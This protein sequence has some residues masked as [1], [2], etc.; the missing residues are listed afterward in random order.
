M[1]LTKKNFN[2]TTQAKN[3]LRKEFMKA[4]SEPKFAKLIEDLKIDTEF[5][6]KYTSNLERVV[7]E[8]ENCKKCKSLA[9]CKNETPGFAY[10][11]RKKDKSLEFYLEACSYYKKEEYKENVKLFDL[12]L[13][14]KNADLK[15]VYTDD[16]NRMKALRAINKF[17]KDYSKNPKG[18]FL[19]GS[20]GSGKT[21]LLAALFNEMAKQGVSSIIVHTP[22]LMRS[23][24]D[25]FKSDY[26]E[27]FYE[28]KTT[29]LLLLDD[30][31]AENISKWSRDE[32]L[33]PILQYR[34][35]QKL[36]TFFT[37]NFSLKDLEEHF[38]I[39]SGSLEKINA[40]RIVERIK[41]LS[42]FI[43]LVSINLR[44]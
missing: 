4:S 16:K 30:I 19:S 2:L 6:M 15:D 35:D 10:S 39:E 22:E 40:R 18:I 13:S 43:E 37:S 41:E 25:S 20:F 28:L 32:V 36:P 34:M 26:K 29:P 12:P 21:Y 23:L 27:R 33:S 11:V 14:L 31:G 3:V 38:Q 5:A 7:V 8:Q 42:E 24:K 9:A 44:G 1:A 17:L